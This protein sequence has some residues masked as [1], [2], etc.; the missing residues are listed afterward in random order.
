M[1]ATITKGTRVRVVGHRMPPGAS[2]EGVVEKVWEPGFAM[3]VFDATPFSVKLEGVAE[4]C[5]FA[6]KDLEVIA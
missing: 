2:G 5:S 1:T 4:Q 3:G 6:A